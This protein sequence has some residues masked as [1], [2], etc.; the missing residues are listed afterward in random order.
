[1]IETAPPLLDQK[2]RPWLIRVAVFLLALGILIRLWY[3]TEMPANVAYELDAAYRILSGQCPYSDFYFDQGLP[4]VA[5]RMLTLAVAP[6]VA[7]A[8]MHNYNIAECFY[9]INVLGD[10][11][12][13]ITS[14]L[15]V[16]SFW[17]C[18]R[19][20]DS[21]GRTT[22][23][24]HI[25]GLILLSFAMANLAMGFEFGDQQHLFVL[26][27]MPYILMRWLVLQGAN[28]PAKYKM[29]TPV[30]AGLGASFNPLFLLSVLTLEI[31]EALARRSVKVLLQSTTAVFLLAATLP[32]LYLLILPKAATQAL[33][34]W[35]LPVKINALSF[36]SFSYYGFG[37]TPD[38]RITI[39]L[40]VFALVFAFGVVK[41]FQLLR[42]LACMAVLGL[43]IWMT[44][45]VGLS[46]DA[47]ILD[48]FNAALLTIEAYLVIDWITSRYP[49]LFFRKKEFACTALVLFGCLAG[50]GALLGQEIHERKLVETGPKRLKPANYE[51][52]PDLVRGINENSKPGDMVLILNGKLRPAYPLMVI[53]G[54]RSCGYFMGSEALG[55]LA[56]MRNFGHFEQGKGIQEPQAKD[57]EKRLYER[58]LADIVREKPELI[59]Q[60]QGEMDADFRLFKLQSVVME[61]YD[62][63]HE[64]RF[65]TDRVGPREIS[66]Y[67]Y[68]YTML[69]LKRTPP[70][71]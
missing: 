23:A 24:P 57:L 1:M 17:L 7:I 20:M 50:S 70:Q 64:T 18:F 46:A 28:V 62:I 68:N 56:D 40:S 60:E 33:F 30:L 8:S 38:G 66:E 42:P 61:Y 10:A 43:M 58:L 32:W 47:L 26:L 22:F 52:L 39:Y 55:T 4:V 48:Y 49:R 11:S 36:D 67:N 14:A 19:L 65:Y 27:F 41:R 12:V 51:D 53:L 44:L 63:V 71:H 9:N 13:L 45:V 37:C 3:A 16:F 25:R 59:C 35:I 34:G 6:L 29:L 15:S 2:Q 69:K 31:A 54:R 5:W 21:F